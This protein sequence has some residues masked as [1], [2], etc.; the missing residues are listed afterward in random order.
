MNLF[1]VLE[2]GARHFPAKEAVRFQAQGVTRSLSYGEL[3]RLAAQF[4][5][6]LAR[7]G[8]RQGDRIAVFLPNLPEYPIVTYGALRIGAVPVLLS[9]A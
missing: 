1:D 6:A 4:S 2:K 8:V 5:A 3:H 7:L 9:S